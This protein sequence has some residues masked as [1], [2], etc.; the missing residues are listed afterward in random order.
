MLTIHWL[1]TGAAL[2][3]AVAALV[4]ARRTSRRLERLTDSYWELRY[5]YGQLRSRVARLEPAQESD[6]P[7]E[8]AARPGPGT[9][10]FVPLSS[11]KR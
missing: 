1:L 3:V 2:L 7:A 10:A 5:E 4:R 6:A 8:P 9:T 11:L